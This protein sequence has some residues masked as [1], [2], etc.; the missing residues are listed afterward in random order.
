MSG[1]QSFT[2]PSLC[3]WPTRPAGRCKVTQKKLGNL[4]QKK[5]TLQDRNLCWLLVCMIISCTYDVWEFERHFVQLEVC[6]EFPPVPDR[7]EVALSEDAVEPS[8]RRE[9]KHCKWSKQKLMS[10]T[11]HT[12]LTRCDTGWIFPQFGKSFVAYFNYSN[13]NKEK[14]A[15]STTGFRTTE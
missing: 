10:I 4:T 2:G 8:Q 7:D 1:H 9:P 3:P 14:H 5:K 6:S 15:V 12:C 11:G 13:K